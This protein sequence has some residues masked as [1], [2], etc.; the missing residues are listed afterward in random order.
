MKSK[1]DNL[2]LKQNRIDA[3]RKAQNKKLEEVRAKY[4]ASVKKKENR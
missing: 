2:H 4:Q 1:A 3:S